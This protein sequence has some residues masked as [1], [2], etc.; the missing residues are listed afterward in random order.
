M[1]RSMMR[2]RVAGRAARVSF[3]ELFFDLVFVFAV[4]QL[5]HTLLAQHAWQGAVSAAFLLLAVWWAWIYTTWVTNWLDPDHPAVR[6][7]LFVLMAL[8][9]VMSIALPAAFGEQAVPF[10][11]AYVTFQLGRTLFMTYATWKEGPLG[12]NFLR[13]SLWFV[14]S[15]V[16]WLI[17]AFADPQARLAIWSVALVIE[18]ISPAAGF[19]VPGLGRTDTT[20]WTVEGGHMAERCGLFIIIC[21]GESVLLTGATFAQAVWEPAATAAFLASLLASIAMWWI[22]FNAHAEA[23][24]EA[25]SASSDPGRIARVAYT[26]AHIPLVAGIIVTAAADELVLA[27]PLGHAGSQAIWLILGGPALFLVGTLWFKYAVFGVFSQSRV[28]GL[29]CLAALAVAAPH[30]SP[31]ALSAAVTTV[32]ALI[33]IWESVAKPHGDKETKSPAKIETAV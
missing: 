19:W 33:A 28:A 21:P 14:L 4:A 17:G 29:V 23:A 31:L 24:A 15:A 30:L 7:V 5:S 9:L 18:Y 12:W 22:Y 16:F 11:L 10:V 2:E 26:Y 1:I 3:V 25:I 20:E 8:G 27:H 6:G 13:A 32:L